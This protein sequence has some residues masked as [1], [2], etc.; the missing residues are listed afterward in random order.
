MSSAILS[1]APMHDVLAYPRVRIGEAWIDALTFDAAI[2][3]I[4]ALVERGTGGVVVTPNVD[5]IVRLAHDAA[6]RAVYARADLSLAD[7]QPVLWAARALGTPLPQKVSGSDLVLPIARLAAERGWRVYLLGG[8]PGAAEGAA[9]RMRREYGTD[10]VGIDAPSVSVD[11]DPATEEAI[12]ARIRVA[13]PHVVLVA[14]GAPK[15]ERLSARIRDAVR[16]AVLLCV[17]V[18]LSFVA[19]HVRRAPAW[20]SRVGLE[21]LY[22]LLQEPRRLWRRYLIEDP[23]FAG[24]VWRT[25]RLPRAEREQPAGAPRR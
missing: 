22:R 13:R 25:A 2:A 21:W 7:G 11:G 8:S 5:H 20:M 1:A 23:Q 17:G 9:E 16:P 12:V 4:A 14:F 15:Q 24:I 19:G 18:S 10:I 3:S 6:F